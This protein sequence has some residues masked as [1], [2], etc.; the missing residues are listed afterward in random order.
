MATDKM[1]TVAGVSE[2]NGEFKVRY[3]NSASRA[4]VLLR[5]G[6]TNVFLI[7]MDDAREKIDCVD[8][9]LGLVERKELTGMGAEAVL[10][11]AREFGFIV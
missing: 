6:H 11:E 2:H 5:N 3:A 4:N 8:V 9:L 1:F 10:A 7:E